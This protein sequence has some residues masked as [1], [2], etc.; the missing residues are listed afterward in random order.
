MK[1]D[2]EV[3]HTSE[4]LDDRVLADVVTAFCRRVN[5]SHDFDIPYIAGYS[6]DAKTIYIDRHL[7]RTLAWKG[8]DF[9]LA[10]FLVTHEIVEKALLDELRLHYLHAHQVALRAERDAVRG[11]GLT[12]RAYQR[13]MKAHEKPI[14]EEKL[15]RVPVDLDL[16]PYE[17]LDDF[18]ILE[19]LVRAAR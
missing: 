15:K 1:L 11:A 16:T 17:D 14:D 10:P 12:W 2:N 4:E 6:D 13:V 19:R 18:Q 8:R 7:P 3:R 5:V 9:R